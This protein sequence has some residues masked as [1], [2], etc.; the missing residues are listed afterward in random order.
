LISIEIIGDSFLIPHEK[1]F[2]HFGCNEQGAATQHDTK[3]R[4]NGRLEMLIT[5]LALLS[6]YTVYFTKTWW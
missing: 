1:S 6:A 5:M 4:S 3:K 2:G